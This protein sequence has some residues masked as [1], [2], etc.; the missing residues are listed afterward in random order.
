LFKDKDLSS[1]D[2]DQDKDC[3]LVLKESLRTR[4]NITVYT[5]A[6]AKKFQIKKLVLRKLKPLTTPQP[7]GNVSS[8]EVAYRL[9]HLGVFY[10]WIGLYVAPDNNLLVPGFYSDDC[11]GDRY[12]SIG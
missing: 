11:R 7:F 4:T 2:K 1:K 10:P 9:P 3:I 8:F 12:R 5:S 6:E